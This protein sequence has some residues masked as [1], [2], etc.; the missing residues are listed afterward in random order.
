M[1]KLVTGFTRRVKSSTSVQNS[2]RRFSYGSNSAKSL[3]I[4]VVRG[5]Y[6]ID[7]TQVD[8][9][10]SK[11]HKA[12]FLNYDDDKIRKYVK[13]GDDNINKLDNVSR[14]SPL[15]LAVV[16]NN[17]NIVKL[18]IASGG[19]LDLVDGDGKTPLVKAIECSHSELV[20]YFVQ[21]KASLNVADTEEGNTAIHVA[22][23]NGYVDGIGILL[24]EPSLDLNKFNF[25]KETPLHLLV[26]NPDLR[27][28]YR[29]VIEQTASVNVQDDRNRSPLM[30]AATIGNREAVQMLIKQGAD[31]NLTDSNGLTASDLAKRNSHTELA[32]LIT[33]TGM[34]GTKAVKPDIPSTSLDD[35]SDSEHSSDEDNVRNRAKSS[36]DPVVNQLQKIQGLKRADGTEHLDAIQPSNV[37]RAVSESAL[38]ADA[39]DGEKEHLAANVQSQGHSSNLSFPGASWQSSDDEHDDDDDVAPFLRQSN[40]RQEVNPS[41]SPT[42]SNDLGHQAED[43]SS[44]PE[45]EALNHLDKVLNDHVGNEDFIQQ[46]KDMLDEDIMEQDELDA[47]LMG[48]P[49]PS[50]P[51]L[52]SLA[53]MASTPLDRPAPLAFVANFEDSDSP[54]SRPTSGESSATVDIKATPTTAG[55]AILINEPVTQSSSSLQ[56]SLTNNHLM[57]QPTKSSGK[58]LPP[59]KALIRPVINLEFD[60]EQDNVQIVPAVTL[61]TEVEESRTLETFEVAHRVEE[62]VEE[63]VNEP[64]NASIK[65]NVEHLELEDSVRVQVSP[66]KSEDSWQEMQSHQVEA[67]RLELFES[68]QSSKPVATSETQPVKVASKEAVNYSDLELKLNQLQSDLI[69]EKRERVSLQ[70]MLNSS[71]ESYS[72]MKQDFQDAFKSKLDLESQVYRLQT[73][74]SKLNYDKQLIESKLESR[75]RE[76]VSAKNSKE[77]SSDEL[78]QS[79]TEKE[80]LVKENS[81]LKYQIKELKSQVEHILRQSVNSVDETINSD[82]MKKIVELTDKSNDLQIELSKSKRKLLD[83]ENELIS[84]RSQFENELL[85]AERIGEKDKRE[86]EHYQRQLSSLREKL[87]M[88]EEQLDR[89]LRNASEDV[90]IRNKELVDQIRDLSE[91]VLKLDEKTS[92]ISAGLANDTQEKELTA[93]IV[94]NASKQLDSRMENMFE[95]TRTLLTDISSELGGFKDVIRSQGNSAHQWTEPSPAQPETVR[96]NSP[97]RPPPGFEKKMVQLE[98]NLE[99]LEDNLQQQELQLL[100]GP[101]HP[102]H[103]LVFT[104]YPGP[105]EPTDQRAKS[106]FVQT[107][108]QLQ[109]QAYSN[110]NAINNYVNMSSFH[111][112]KSNLQQQIEVLKHDLGIFTPSYQSFELDQ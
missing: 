52:S 15:H 100:I 58:S 8:V 7:L 89:K 90:V 92:R 14:S 106:V 11:L 59:V 17:V 103:Q 60:F 54:S 67:E 109:A 86:I 85:I 107:L 91:V 22:I 104:G 2:S 61:R 25:N 80:L 34:I 28:F 78:I 40:P 29:Q 108:L 105:L 75:E 6:N 3:N 9:T 24:N 112:A 62:Q 42:E 77:Q 96:Q 10:F 47:M 64:K 81:D 99:K 74:L 12:C 101:R 72:K 76:F 55:A 49:V 93:A 68:E 51:P 48:D 39:V 36:F 82:N 1:K 102:A 5:G 26:K 21:S 4:Q 84:Q 88:T 45:A 83:L 79:R 65:S 94:E 87:L 53:A 57:E 20:H 98:T 71:N 18:L 56:T 37:R 44:R 33:G 66:V 35:W 69:K 73:E 63:E 16:N 50:A 95:C 41:L 19:H 97:I 38:L 23:N 13:Q 27:N 46:L 31:T 110:P 43:S 30:V 32:S 70:D 111:S